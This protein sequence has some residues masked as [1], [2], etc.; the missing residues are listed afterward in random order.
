MGLRVGWRK[1][2]CPKCGNLHRCKWVYKGIMLCYRCYQ[3]AFTK[4][5]YEGSSDFGKLRKICTICGKMRKPV[6]HRIN[7]NDKD[8][9]FCKSCLN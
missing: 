6:V 3:K 5:K 4:N 2:I 7:T 9:W 8:E 1:K